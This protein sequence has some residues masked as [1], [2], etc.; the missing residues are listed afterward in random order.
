[1]PYNFTY[2]QLLKLAYPRV[3]AR[4]LKQKYLQGNYEPGEQAPLAEYP[5]FGNFPK[6][7][8]SDVRSEFMGA[9]VIQPVKF[10]T[11]SYRARTNDTTV[12]TIEYDE[13]LTP[14]S[15]IVDIVQTKHIVTTRI[16]G[17][18]G[19]VKEFISNG[20]YQV[21][22]RGVMINYEQDDLPEEK[23]RLMKI[24]CDVPAAVKVECELLE[25]FGIYE[26]AIQSY[27]LP[28]LEGFTNLQ[29][30]TIT[31]LSDTPI[32]LRRIQRDFL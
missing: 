14:P 17:R 16:T 32:E 31:A 7:T 30:F 19:T 4:I 2:E 28:A 5:R 25:W 27:S 18:S 20:D 3:Q 13:W 24:I 9:P 12:S 23:I 11:G 26:L 21:T 1:M 29:P 22:L 8:D 6:P 10:L 15:T